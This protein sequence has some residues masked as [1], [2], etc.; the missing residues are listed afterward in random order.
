MEHYTLR[1]RSQTV[2]ED[3]LFLAQNYHAVNKQKCRI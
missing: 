1:E 2:E 3:E